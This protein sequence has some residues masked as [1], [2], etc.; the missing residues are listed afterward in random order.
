MLILKAT[1]T[2]KVEPYLDFNSSVN[3]TALTIIDGKI[4]AGRVCRHYKDSEEV[5][6]MNDFGEYIVKECDIIGLIKSELPFYY[7]LELISSL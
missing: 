3:F 7:D 6:L 4:L 1:T 5:C 2:K